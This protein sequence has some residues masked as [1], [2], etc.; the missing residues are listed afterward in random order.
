MVWVPVRFGKSEARICFMSP[1]VGE[2]RYLMQFSTLEGRVN[3]L[4]MVTCE[5]GK[6]A[7]IEVLLENPSARPATLSY[8]L[9][10]AGLFFV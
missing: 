9:T 6:A 3:K 2:K 1:E 5:L 8:A 10:E 4:P 7:T